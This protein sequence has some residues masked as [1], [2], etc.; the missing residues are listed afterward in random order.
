VDRHRLREIIQDGLSGN[1]LYPVVKKR[2][3]FQ[4]ESKR[5]KNL[6]ERS[7]ELKESQPAKS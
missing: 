4:K 1:I 5:T 6:N 7:T 3:R 2:Y